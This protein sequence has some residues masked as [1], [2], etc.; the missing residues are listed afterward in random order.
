L[1]EEGQLITESYRNYSRKKIRSE[2]SSLDDFLRAWND[3]KKKQLII[4]ELEGHGIDFA[5]LEKEIANGCGAFD[6]ICHIA[7]DQPPLTRAERANNVKKRNYFTKYG[8]KARAILEALL[9]KYADEDIGAIESAKVLRYRPFNEIG[10]P[11]EIINE[12]FGGKDGYE[13]AIEELEHAIYDLKQST[14]T[15]A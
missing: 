4:D 11:V 12:V 7:Y 15:H 10:T 3:A 6:L 5:H 1:S 9:N 13:H 14:G 8:D 2:F